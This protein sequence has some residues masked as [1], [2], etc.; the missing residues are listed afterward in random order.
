MISLR[1]CLVKGC[2]GTLRAVQTG[3]YH[4]DTKVSKLKCNKCG[5]LACSIQ[6]LGPIELMKFARVVNNLGEKAT[7][8]RLR[9]PITVDLDPSLRPEIKVHDSNSFPDPWM[10]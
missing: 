6:F 2:N 9:H 1:F 4:M 5:A 7:A 10:E 3:G 8:P